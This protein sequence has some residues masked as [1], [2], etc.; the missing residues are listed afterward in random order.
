M[1]GTSN[2]SVPEMA[3][4]EMVTFT[5]ETVKFLCGEIVGQSLCF[6]GGDTENDGLSMKNSGIVVKHPP[7]T[8][9]DA[10]NH[11]YLGDILGPFHVVFRSLSQG[12]VQGSGAKRQQVHV[13]H[14]A[15][16]R[17]AGLS[18]DLGREADEAGWTT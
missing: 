11:I 6:F 2:K 4:E 8:V 17:V 12:D 10:G 1:V 7:E 18:W 15:H 5:I 14:L 9:V 16:V 3:I 13:P